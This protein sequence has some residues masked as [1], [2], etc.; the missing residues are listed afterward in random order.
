MATS[1]SQ[2]AFSTPRRLLAVEELCKPLGQPFEQ[3]NV[4]PQGIKLSSDL[5]AAGGGTLAANTK[6]Q[7]IEPVVAPLRRSPIPPRPSSQSSKPFR[8]KTPV[9]QA[10]LLLHLPPLHGL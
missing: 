9:R 6:A 1:C 4:E 2:S 10:L 5:S 8:G 7:S 3:P